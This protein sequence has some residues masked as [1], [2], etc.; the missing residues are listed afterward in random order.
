MEKIYGEEVRSRIS[1]QR[2][3]L[4]FCLRFWYRR[5]VGGMYPI[6]SSS[7]NP[8]PH[9]MNAF[10]ASK[11]SEVKWHICLPHPSLRIAMNVFMIHVKSIYDP[12]QR[13]KSHRL[14]FWGKHKYINPAS[15]LIKNLSI[16]LGTL[17]RKRVHLEV[18]ATTSSYGYI[19]QASIKEE[20]RGSLFQVQEIL[21]EKLYL[22]NSWASWFA[23]WG[24]KLNETSPMAV[25]LSI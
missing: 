9:K 23:S 15:C 3:G 24:Q 4:F 1:R 25:T 11:P 20:A 12:C 18:A 16:P 6:I 8:H 22:A 14:S 7:V 5:C 13:V 17:V 10:L 19:V 2:K 21:L